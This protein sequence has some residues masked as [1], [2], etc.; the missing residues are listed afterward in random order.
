[1]NYILVRAGGQT[2]VS[3]YGILMYV[4]GFIQPLLYGMC[5]SLQPAVGFNWGAGKYSRVRAIEKCCFVSS[6]VV[7]ILS[8]FVICLLP[9]Q[10]TNLFL[11]ESG[12]DVFAMSVAALPLF[13]LTYITR[14]FS[15]A[16]QSYMLAVEKPMPA[17]LISVSTALIFPVILIFALNPF[18]L[19]GIWLNFAGTSV[20]AAIMSAVI[21]ICLRRQLSRQDVP[22]AQRNLLAQEQAGE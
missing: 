8:V 10:I 6:A 19:T 18:G 14:W 2:A 21:L 13:G 20:L 11:G 4:E 15:F 9:E 5:D 7:S 12:A 22:E 1:M 17:S 16:T 3:V